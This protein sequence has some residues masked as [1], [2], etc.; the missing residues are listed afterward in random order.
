MTSQQTISRTAEWCCALF[1]FLV[2]NLAYAGS[3]PLNN[4]LESNAHE[5]LGADGQVYH[6]MAKAFPREL[7]P[8]GVAPF[9][10]RIG[11]PFLASTLAKSQDWVISAG[12]D[13]LNVAFNALSVVLL[14]LL[15][16]RH[17]AGVFVRLLIVAA[18]MVEPHSP[19]RLSYFQPLS[20]EPA[21]LAGLL[22]GLL[23]IEWFQ[24]RPGPARAMVV[25]LVVAIGVVFHEVLLV[26]GVCVL[27]GAIATAERPSTWR[28]KLK[29]LDATGAWLPLISGVAMLVA[30]HAWVDATP[31][32]Y[33]MS[34]EALHWLRD[35]SLFQYGIAWFLVFGP[36]LAVP[37]YFWRRSSGWLW[38]QPVLLA[39][40]SIFVILAWVGGGDTERLLVLAS[41]VVYLVIGRAMTWASARQ[42]TVATAGLVLA[43]AI[44]SRIFSPIGGPVTPPEIG[45]EVWERLGWAGA[46]WTLSYDNMW[47]QSCAPSMMVTYWLCYG[48]TVASVLAFLHYG[49]GETSGA[50][51]GSAAVVSRLAIDWRRAADLMPNWTTRFLIGL[52]TLA[53]LAPVVWLSLSRFYWIHYDQPGSAY[54][55]YNLARLWTVAVLLLVFWATGSRILGYKSTS[56][57]TSDHWTDR[58]FDSAFCGAAAWA[59]G[60][61]L[62]ATVRLYYIWVI[63][64]LVSVAVF[65]AVSQLIAAR[66][67]TPSS[68]DSSLIRERWGFSG[69]L[70]RLA[71]AVFAGGLLLTI[72]LWANPGPDNDVPG[73]YLPYYEEVLRAH[74]NGPNGYWV[75]YFVSKGHGLAFLFNILSDVQG[76]ALASWLVL[77]MGAGMIW[78]LATRYAS[79]GQAIALVGVCLYLQF[80]AEQGAYAKG[81]IIRNTLILYLILSFARGLYFRVSDTKSNSIGR[82]VVITAVMFLSPLAVVLLLPIFLMEGVL[83]RLSGDVAGVKRSLIYP[84]WAVVVAALACSYN[85][86][87]VGVPELHNMPSFI[88][89]FV[90]FERLSQWLDPRLSF[91]DYRLEFLQLAVLGSDPVAASTWRLP[92]T[93]PVMAVIS[94]VLNLSTLIWLGGAALIG[95][96]GIVVSRSSGRSRESRLGA[97]AASAALYLAAS[98]AM[99]TILRLFG[100]GPGSSMARFTDFTTPLGIALGV[101][102]MT[103][104]WALSMSPS[105]RRVLVAS[106]SCVACVSIYF[107]AAPLMAQLWRPSVGFLLGQNTYAA[108]YD[109]NW[110]TVVA[111]RM[112]LAIPGTE[113]AELL[114]FLPG[115]TAVPAT[116]FQRPDGGVYI[117]DYITILYG[118]V[119]QAVDAYRAS[120]VS[121]FLFD[122]SDSAIAVGG[123]APLFSPESIRSRM[124]LVKHDASERRDLYLL[125]WKN[126]QVPVQDEQFDVFL[127]KWGNKLDVEKESGTYHWAYDQGARLMR[128][129]R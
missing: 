32:G 125:T 114:N 29:A 107:G 62:L 37:I 21:M 129:G 59:V 38:E 74:S 65:L 79:S 112:A 23:G 43:Q 70:L 105:S 39:Y 6:A 45:A 108:I 1:A 27:F 77:T 89:R 97:G 119:D 106:I 22:A 36:I 93:V 81:H 120:G 88:G 47:S 109:L 26:I 104:T 91:V 67:N 121:Y 75:H 44:S 102:L 58:F 64:P 92:D 118:S 76:A 12:F 85:Y 111:R 13:R 57:K 99:V 46:A 10:Y 35:K 42:V 72:A 51:R 126:G 83:T 56:S 82:M 40:L 16:Q 55:V 66:R 49:A 24:A 9:V 124:R 33:S 48:A 18:F 68:P 90:D 63:L 117:K 123:F 127:Q 2:L 128:R 30:V 20:L 19:V 73:N 98:L 4:F 3:Q 113:K 61:T 28:D 15:L 34:G 60:V 95:A 54:L 122:T 116:P 5:E 96:F 8:L 14:L 11:T 7:P 110:D 86:Y 100:G 101:V 103:A 17:V 94:R 69:L 78:R 87:E 50:G 80:F 25:A 84:A 71:V 53:A 41:P 52:C 115:F 31:S